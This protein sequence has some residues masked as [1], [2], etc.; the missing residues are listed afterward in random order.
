MDFSH[1]E[2]FRDNHF[3]VT[4]VYELAVSMLLWYGS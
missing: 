2:Q 3:G 4:R 1:K